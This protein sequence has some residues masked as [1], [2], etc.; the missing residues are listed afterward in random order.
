MNAV[1]GPLVGLGAL[2][3]LLVGGCGDSGPASPTPAPPPTSSVR[4]DKASDLGTLVALLQETGLSVNIEPQ[5]TEFL[6]SVDGKAVAVN[7]QVIEV[8]EYPYLAS[9]EADAA[10]V[11]PDGTKITEKSADSGR[12][13][14]DFFW[15]APPHFYRSGTLIVLY[16]GDDATI[17]EALEEVVGPQ[18][19]GR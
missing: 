12:V 7:D 2:I 14:S 13:A 16:V 5:S 10:R 3:V 11:S 1:T 6:F 19:A 17:K 9:A 4:A 18:F 8:F 15:H